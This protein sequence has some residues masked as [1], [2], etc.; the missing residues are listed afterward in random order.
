[1]LKWNML[2]HGV[3]GVDANSNDSGDSQRSPGLMKRQNEYQQINNY[4]KE[5]RLLYSMA[6]SHTWLAK[7]IHWSF[8]PLY[9]YGIFKQLDDLSQLEETKLLLFEVFF[10]TLFLLIVVLRYTYMRRF[11]TFLGAREPVH[12]VHHF[13]AKT[14]HMSMYFCLVL[15]PLSGL[16][17]A[18]L[19]RWGVEEEGILMEGT[20]GLHAFAADL[21]YALIAVHVVAAVYS[22]LKNEGVWTS[23]VPVF[24]EQQKSAHPS[25]TR[26]AEV[27]ERVYDQVSRFFSSKKD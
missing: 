26:F 27:E 8:I 3:F 4:E 24:A 1:M 22:R 14:V 5:R 12:P 13:F 17:I 23:M 16:A 25:V 2:E 6:T 21:S 7:F 10:A 18:G 19:F 9:L 15:L 11:E 20:L